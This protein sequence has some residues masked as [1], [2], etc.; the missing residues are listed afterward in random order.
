MKNNAKR[1]I[2]ALLSLLLLLSMLP[3]L[4]MG[5][6]A[7]GGEETIRIR[8]AGDLLELAERCALDTWSRGKTVV[9]EADI[10]LEGSGF[11][12]IPTFSGVFE[13][14]GHT[15]SGLDMEEGVTPAG[16]FSY[17]E[18]TAVVRELHVT[19]SVIPSG[20]GET[21]GGIA[22]E[23]H[24]MILDC[25][26]SGT[27]SSASNA[28]GIAGI[29]AATGVIQ[30][31]RTDGAVF[32]ESMTGGVAGYNMGIVDH[33][34]NEAYVNI[35]SED[36][37]LD[38]QRL[39]PDRLLNISS[40]GSLDISSAASDT[41]GIAGYS[42]GVIQHCTNS[43]AVGY[44]HIGYNVG[45]I[46][47]RSCGYIFS[48]ENTADVYGRK[49]VG[50]IAGQ[51]EPYIAMDLSE[52]SLTE[53]RR[54][55]DTLSAMVDAAIDDAG[56]GV[57]SAVS[58][59]N[60]IADYLDSA[61]AAAD[62]LSVSGSLSGA[63]SG[64]GAVNSDGSVTVRPPQIVAGGSSSAEGGAETE[65]DPPSAS[66]S[67]GGSSEG[68]FH[69]GLSEGGVSGGGSTQGGGQATADAQIA[70]RA[71][72]GGLVSAVNGMTGQM[73]LLSSETAGTAGAL[74]DDLRA[75]SSQINAISDTVFDA[76]LGSGQGETVSDTSETDIDAVTLGKTASSRNSGSIC[77]DI[78][79][80]GIA[81][82]MAVEYELDPEDDVASE[83]S[84]KQRRSYELKAI[85]QGCVNDG[86]VTAKRSY[87]GGVCGRMDLGLLCDSENYGAVSSEN[88]DYVGGIAGLTGGTLRRSYAKC[89]LRGGSYVGGIT[90]SGVSDESGESHSTVSGCYSMVSIPECEQYAG[91]VSGVN[92]GVFTENYF[93]SNSL[94]GINRLSY[95][96]QAEPVDYTELTA[97]DAQ[98]ADAAKHVVPEAFLQLRLRFLAEGETVKTVEFAYGQSFDSS[99]FPAVPEKEGCCGVWD[100]DELK[101][102][103][104]DTVVTAVYT[105]CISSLYSSQLRSDDRPVFFVEG[106]FGDGAAVSASEQAAA[107]EE[108]D[109]AEGWWDSLKKAFTS[110]RLR[111]GVVEQW[112]LE[113]TP[114]GQAEHTFHYLP[115]SGEPENMA[116]Y[117][118]TD[119][120]WKETS[121]ET[122]GS[123]LLFSAPGDEAEVAV[124][125][126][127]SVRWVWLAAAL[128]LLLLLLPLLLLI[129][130]ARR[131]RAEE[132]RR[133][134]AILAAAAA[135]RSLSGDE[136]EPAP[137]AQQTAPRKKKSRRLLKVLAVLLL[138][139]AAAGAAAWFLL[140]GL[141][142][143]REAYALL[144]S[145][146]EAEELSMDL[147]VEARLDG[148]DMG[149]EA[150]LARTQA[151]G[152]S[153]TV[154]SQNGRTLCYADDA[155]FLENGKAYR[156]GSACPDYTALL[157]KALPLYQHAD[158]SGKDGVYR[159]TAEGEDAEAILRLLLPA[160]DGLAAADAVTVELVSEG[161]EAEELRFTFD[162]RLGSAAQKPCTVSAVLDLHAGEEGRPTVPEAVEDR[163]LAGDYTAE[164]DL[165]EDLL[166]LLSAWGELGGRDPLRTTVA[167]RAD[168]GPLILNDSLELYRTEI[169]GLT[170]SAVEKSGTRL[171]FTENALCDESGELSLSAHRD[172]VA[173]AELP[174]LLYLL[175]ENGDVTCTSSGE[176][177]S[178]ALTL[179]E[180]GARRV[181]C[182]IAPAA[183]ELDIDFDSGSVRLTVS[184]G[185]LRTVT[186][187]CSGRLQLLLSSAEAEIGAELAFPE[188]YADFSV[189]D[190]VYQVLK[191]KEAA[192]K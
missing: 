61:A 123:Y 175:C 28:G 49:D 115:P 58:R 167:L 1:I 157:E 22:G 8:S 15:I 118:K 160:A 110:S 148:Q 186:V 87:A 143:G 156:I 189:P 35:T 142:E 17:L 120:G 168:C 16:L 119:G 72:L 180:E 12:P 85:L 103:R 137:A 149:F 179:D 134:E 169:R 121:T 44:Q 140:P 47:G 79:V 65:F 14:Q 138:L 188:G 67:A 42:T 13:G 26:F 68:E 150:R 170:V 69:A 51:L 104:Q 27:V 63:V 117:V 34:E 113:L 19:G 163:L 80:G 71:S 94:A 31:C 23:N 133:L 45:G 30:N 78:S 96:G 86:E 43:A 56:A 20:D 152:Q 105:P 62:G 126:T 75:I 161:A 181:A 82:A 95:A 25:S 32:G 130:R 29:N 192:A 173:A 162:G 84:G 93:V 190:E 50:G 191:E 81:G 40:L 97:A 151:A 145:C 74:N 164:A 2:A 127:V 92:R 106:Q 125:S 109:I 41:G 107:P 144:K 101:D 135:G 38:L 6:R 52:D 153:V 90:G 91:A 18:E 83:L 183:E 77:G 3:V 89:T 154:I 141:T 55:M 21:A 128:L 37:S 9:L 132:D 158:I 53:L 178:Y 129:R 165:S 182:A 185:K 112:R 147:A 114:D 60:R 146:A 5:V 24:G 36:P 176:S 187:A 124:L 99:V 131:R 108:F 11:L 70:L 4:P 10:S 73:R 139:C 64:S 177:R 7:E 172:D 88:G 174:E 54:Q 122:M 166:I 155:V 76:L 33:C 66:G 111:R 116:V 48:C 39:N 98:E 184:D 159:V 136:P 57:S 171:Y 59:L 102:L 46:A 100:A